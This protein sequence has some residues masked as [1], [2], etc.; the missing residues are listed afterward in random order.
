MTRPVSRISDG[1]NTIGLSKCYRFYC[2]ILKLIGCALYSSLKD[3]G[4]CKY[5][6]SYITLA[7]LIFKPE[8]AVMFYALLLGHKITGNP[9]RGLQESCRHRTH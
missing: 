1:T 6:R 8:R 5:M 3:L 2:T 9:R 4:W 7:T